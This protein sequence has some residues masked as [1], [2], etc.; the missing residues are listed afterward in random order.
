MTCLHDFLAS[1]EWWRLA[2][3]P[4]WIRNPPTEYLHRSVLAHTARGD[5]AVAYLP[6]QNGVD[7]DL[8][9]FAA[10]VTTEW[11]DP[12][13]GKYAA[14]DSK[15]VLN[16]AAHHFTPPGKNSAGDDDWVLVLTTGPKK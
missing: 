4:E 5:L 12:T 14:A 8:S 2:P 1:I 10:P 9:G 13:S 11:F 3:V 15:P 7:I 16:Q 6:D